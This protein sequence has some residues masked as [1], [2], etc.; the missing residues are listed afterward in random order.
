V[1][2]SRA[3][4]IPEEE[5]EGAPEMQA[6]WQRSRQQLLS[7]QVLAPGN[8]RKHQVQRINHPTTTDILLC[9]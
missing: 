9:L 6:L 2:A 1:Q 7:E 5:S 8:R 4:G 3:S